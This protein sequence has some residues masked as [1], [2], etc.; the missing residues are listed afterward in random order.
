MRMRSSDDKN[1]ENSQGSGRTRSK[2]IKFDP[3]P[4]NGSGATATGKKRPNNEQQSVRSEKIRRE[5]SYSKR[6]PTVWDEDEE[7]QLL[8]AV[9]KHGAGNWKTILDDK[10]FQF[11]LRT[12]VDL[13]DKYRSLF[14]SS[15]APPQVLIGTRKP[16]T[17]LE[18]QA[19]RDGI[20]LYGEGSWKIILDDPQFGIVLQ[21]RSNQQLKDKFRT[22]GRA[23]PSASWSSDEEMALIEGIRKYGTKNWTELLK[24]S[25]Y[26]GRLRGGRSAVQLESH[27]Q[28]L[29]TKGR[30]GNL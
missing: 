2:T 19:L 24:D 6:T 27:Y 26:A 14:K 15:K 28:V 30:L 3:S 16:W 20:E 9:E 7:L 25:L 5:G 22:L 17:E 12:N 1:S 11:N 18:E 10:G 29:K 23:R 13:K 4:E 8:R 21:N